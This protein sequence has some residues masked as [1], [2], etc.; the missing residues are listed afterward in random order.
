MAAPAFAKLLGQKANKLRGRLSQ[1]SGM[2][3]V[4]GAKV[5]VF[6]IRVLPLKSRPKGFASSWN[7]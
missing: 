3:P 5:V 4:R 7:Q 1:Q 2:L 6:V